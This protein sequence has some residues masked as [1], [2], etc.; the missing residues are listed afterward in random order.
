VTTKGKHVWRDDG[1][2][3][4]KETSNARLSK[5]GYHVGVFGQNVLIYHDGK[6][7]FESEDEGLVD[8]Y[9]KLLLED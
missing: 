4:V 1:W 7:V 3:V 6:V 5:M 2:L 8:N 9:L